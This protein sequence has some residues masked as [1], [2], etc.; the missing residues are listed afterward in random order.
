MNMLKPFEYPKHIF[1]T[2]PD[3]APEMRA[4]LL[5]WSETP[6]GNREINSQQRK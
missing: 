5:P 1:E 6:Q 4:S 2:M 3:I